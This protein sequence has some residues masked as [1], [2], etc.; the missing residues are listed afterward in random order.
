[1]VGLGKRWLLPLAGE[2]ARSVPYHM[3]T[4]VIIAA[5]SLLALGC[6]AVAAPVVVRDVQA[7]RVP[8]LPQALVVSSEAPGQGRQG[9]VAVPVCTWM[10]GKP[11]EYWV[12]TVSEYNS[13]VPNAAVPLPHYTVREY[14]LLLSVTNATPDRE[15]VIR[16]VVDPGMSR[17]LLKLTTE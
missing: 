5:V 14:D 17:A 11:R 12:R 16:V 8:A 1:M 3:R 2:V 15:P 13:S 10:T 4:S 6:G 7:R 9:P